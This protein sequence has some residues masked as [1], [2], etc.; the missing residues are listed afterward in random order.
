MFPDSVFFSIAVVLGL[1]ALLGAIGQRL[2]QPLIIMFLLTGI[3]AGPGGLGLMDSEGNFELLAQ[4]GVALLLFIVGLKL[5]IHLIKSIGPVALATG[6]GQIVFTSIIGFIITIILGM[7]LVSALYVSVAL[8]FSS[9]IIIVKLLSDKKEIDSLH[10]QIALGFLIVQDIVAIIALVALTTLGADISG[11]MAPLV[12][13]LI[14]AGKGVGFLLFVG[15]VWK[16]VIPR[17]TAQLARS[18]ELLALFA[19]AWA[20]ILG[21]VSEVLGFTKEVGAFVAGISL[22]STDYRDAI[23]A[24]LTGLRDFLLLFFFIGLGT[25]LHWDA[26]GS[27]IGTSIILSIFVLVG[28]PLIVCAIM[29]F[30]GYRRRT[31]FLAGLTVAQI[32]EF[33]LVV[34][35]LGLGLGHI[36]EETMGVVT[37]VGVVTI[38]AS[39]YMILYSEKLY[40]VFSGPLKIFE[41][42]NPF[43]EIAI[44]SMN[45]AQR[46]DVILVGLGQ[47]GSEI[48]ENLLR[49]NK[50]LIAVDYDPV[51]L[52]RWKARGVPVLYGDIADS[53]INDHLPIDKAKW[54]VST[55]RVLELNLA[56]LQNL[57]LRGFKGKVALTA[58]NQREARIYEKKGASLIFRPFR[59][60]SEQAVESLTHMMDML[61]EDANCAVSFKEVLL[62]RWPG[63]AGRKIRDLPL[64]A[65]TG[66]SILAVKRSG[67]VNN[68]PGPDFRLFQGDRLVIVGLPDKLEMAERILNEVQDMQT[69]DRTERFQ[70]A[71][72]SVAKNP[73]LSGRTLADMRFRQEYG[74]TVLGVKHGKGPVLGPDPGYRFR[75]GDRLMVIG[76][77]SAVSKMK[78]S[79]LVCSR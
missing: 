59:D 47:Y 19:I 79:D 31:G 32:S 41:R 26:V 36:S 49:R 58:V 37:L 18:Q 5:D 55:V 77:A 43:R 8:T 3:L 61:P 10:G 65:I 44:D 29:G 73:Q 78:S 71:E 14:M 34:A 15:L 6:L 9:T 2:R 75:S 35:T 12:T 22:A 40:R 30:M 28:N 62:N 17:L 72:L 56:L 60:A 70:L 69:G 42:K 67:M 1:A 20:V 45:D 24:R 11:G 16:F 66:V 4:I 38:F 52:K 74:V 13:Y 7:S 63:T 27:K 39:T 23:G 21:S 25:H 54:V 46:A 76:P 48:A 68:D 50:R 53:E 51:V 57:K 64:R 33:S